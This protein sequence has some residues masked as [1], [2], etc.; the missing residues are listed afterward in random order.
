MPRHEEEAVPTEA[1]KEDHLA[2]CL[3]EAALGMEAAPPEA[4]KAVV[5][6][7]VAARAV[8]RAAA[9]MACR[10]HTLRILGTPGL[11]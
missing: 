6:T 5:T 10:L 9:A 4:A 3:V 8:A 11:R 2:G 1:G 7:V